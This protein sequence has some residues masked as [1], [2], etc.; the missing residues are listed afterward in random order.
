MFILFATSCNQK[1]KTTEGEDNKIKFDTISATKYHYLNNDSTLPSCNLSIN[2]S[3]PLEFENKEVLAK[4]K[5]AFNVTLFDENYA[6]T[7]ITEAIEKYYYFNESRAGHDE[8]ADRYFSYYE[9]ISNEIMFNKGNILSVQFMHSNKKSNNNT[10]RQYSNKVFD[11]STGDLLDEKDIFKEDYDK[12]L[13]L[14]FRNKLLTANKVKNISEL[15]ELGYFGIEEMIPNNNFLLNNEGVTYVFNKGEYSVL[16]ADEITLFIPYSE[17]S[18][19]LKE[20][21]PISIFYN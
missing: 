18:E 12:F 11:L 5:T 15:E 10:F 14:V 17:I 4:L 16:K 6:D 2:I 13:T 3:Y 19:I 9:K 7:N 8:S 21:S 20:K 1:N